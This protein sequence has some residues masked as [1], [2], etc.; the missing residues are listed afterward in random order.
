[1]LRRSAVR[2]VGKVAFPA[3]AAIGIPGTAGAAG[4]D[5]FIGFGDSSMDSGYFRYNPTGG[6]PSRPPGAPV[7]TID[8][9]VR[10][11]VAA[12]GTGT[13]PGPALVDSQII[14]ARFS[15]TAVPFIV[16]GGGGTNYAN[17]SAQAV[18]TTAAD[19]YVHGLY[20][21]VPIVTQMSNYLASV[22][23]VAN[24]N[25]LYMVSYGG[26]DLIWLQLQGQN[27][28][29]LPYLSIQAQSLVGGITSL[30]AAGARTIV[31]LDVYAKSKLVDA[32]GGLSPSNLAVVNQAT[33]YSA[34]VWSGLK[35][36]GV[37]FIPVDIE[38][39]LT[40]ASQN[41]ARFGF[42]AASV[43]ASN[44]ACG[45]TTGL[46]CAPGDLVAPNAEQTHLWSD[47]N[48][49]TTAGQ[50][51]ESDLMYDVITAPSQI[52]LLAETAVQGGLAR[53][54]TIQGQIDL[55]GQPRG[56]N[57]INTWAGAGVSSLSL[58]NTAS[59]PTESGT[60]FN[61]T[62]GTD[63][64]LPDGVIVGAALTAGGQTQ[65]FSSGGHLNQVDEALSL[66]AAYQT[67][68][69]WG[70]AIASYGLLQDHVARQVPLGI[71]TDQ[72]NADTSGESWGLGL[73]GGYDLHFGPFTTGPVVGMVMQQIRI[74]GFTETGTT[75][76]TALSFA[77]QTRN[78]AITQ[79]GWCGSVDIGNWQPFADAEWNHELGGQNRSITAALTSIPAPSYTT[80]A[81]P[82]A[83]DWAS[84]SLGV[85]Y[86]L[87]QQVM[88]RGGILAE[89]FSPQVIS[90][91]GALGVSVG[92]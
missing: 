51:I 14:A 2:W 58:K 88:L 78:S 3:L 54:A 50:T 21:N 64:L 74:K 41:P 13:F 37:N 53:M 9:L 38:N 73:R 34:E 18:S 52:S 65:N 86:K 40:Y 27:V 6:A 81:A 11:T 79:F 29:A 16:A 47:P 92:F 71:F 23:N 10:K 45:T 15:L 61:G 82:I 25:A 44:P 90:Y 75:G 42:T 28:A 80:P 57:G 46:V 68:A 77:S 43:L 20:N 12:G 33:A 67:G 7:T 89:V 56:P 59:F 24:P 39:A 35:A 31:V 91:G 63:Y 36:A 26:N 83:S 5:Q 19:A 60:P 4:F 62:V 84:L 72:N 17:G 49:L 8:M 87:N 32:D 48:H 70:N 66:Y 69:V 55:S 30:Q 85:S 76:I 1:M 22:H